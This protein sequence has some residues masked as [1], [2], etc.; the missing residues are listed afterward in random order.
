MDRAGPAVGGG[1]RGGFWRFIFLFFLS[2]FL[3]FSCC[4]R[5]SSCPFQ[6]FYCFVVS[7][8]RRLLLL[9]RGRSFSQTLLKIQGV[10]QWR[11]SEVLEQG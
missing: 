6:G 10:R 2:F 9:F 8:L 1:G 11:Q 5:C 3:R 7:R 4:S